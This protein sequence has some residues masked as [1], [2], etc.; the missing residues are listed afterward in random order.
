M[1]HVVIPTE[2]LW[3]EE[4]EEFQSGFSADFYIEHSLYAIS[5]WEEKY[6]KPFF[7]KGN[8]N[9]KHTMTRAE[10]NDYIFFAVVEPKD[11]KR[12]WM[13]H[14]TPDNYTEIQKYMEQEHSASTIAK[15]EP[16]R[17]GSGKFL[18][19]ELIYSYMVALQIPF[20]CQYWN[21]NRLFMLIQMCNEHNQPTKK[22]SKEDNIK[23][24]ARL[25]KAR[26]S[27][28]HM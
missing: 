5:K 22:M 15:K 10:L 13:D 24:M 7:G 28:P 1:L 12:E 21:L 23:N 2:E 14:L 16:S 9:E 17:G 18:T 3:N 26:K 27:K 11:A 25:N 6:E 20:E 8:K 19:S 4:T